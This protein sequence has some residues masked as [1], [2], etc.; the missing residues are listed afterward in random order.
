VKDIKGPCLCGATDCP[1]C[2]PFENQRVVDPDEEEARAEAYFARRFEDRLE[3]A[4]AINEQLRG[5][6]D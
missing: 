3:Q 2:Y 4:Q 6:R 1:R 5:D